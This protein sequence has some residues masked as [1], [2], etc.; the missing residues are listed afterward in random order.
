MAEHLIDL[1]TWP[2]T[3]QFELFRTYQAPR[4]VVTTR[5]DATHLMTRAKLRGVSPYRACLYAIGAGVHGVPELLTRFRG[6]HPLR[7]DAVDL[8]MTVPLEKGGYGYAYVPFAESFTDFDAASAAI[9]QQVAQGGLLAPNTGQ[10]DDLAYLSCMPWLDFTS[11]TNALPG[12]E[13]CIPRISWGKFVQ[14]GDGWDMA[15]ALDVHHALVDG[16]HIG[17][18]FDVAQR[19][20]DKL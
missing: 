17:A 2:R 1:A 16:E 10:R 9:I 18:F 14:R 15:I 7:H 3:P 11:I 4:Y 12:P 5:I 8:S 19:A 13:D 6:D 20:L